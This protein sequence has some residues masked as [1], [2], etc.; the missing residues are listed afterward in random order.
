MISKRIALRLTTSLFEQERFDQVLAWQNEEA[1]TV[2]T[3]GTLPVPLAAL[4]KQ[5]MTQPTKSSMRI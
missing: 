4:R 1:E 5:R 3:G 2:V